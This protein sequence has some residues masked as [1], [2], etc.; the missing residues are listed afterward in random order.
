MSFTKTYRNEK[1]KKGQQEIERKGKDWI[2]GC[3]DDSNIYFVDVIHFSLRGEWERE[4]W[5]PRVGRCGGLENIPFCKIVLSMKQ[6][7]NKQMKIVKTSLHD[8]ALSHFRPY[9]DLRE[10]QVR[11]RFCSDE[12]CSSNDSSQWVLNFQ[13]S[14]SKIL[15]RCLTAESWAENKHI[16]N[17]EVSYGSWINKKLNSMS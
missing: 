7:E 16:K 5:E 15:S 11:K 4:F 8:A 14:R 1:C 6:K 9:H 12:N 3:D 2:E 13:L 10:K 17:L